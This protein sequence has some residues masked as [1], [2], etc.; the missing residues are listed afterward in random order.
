M[1]KGYSYLSFEENT[2]TR[3]VVQIKLVFA[4][5]LDI[6]D[7]NYNEISELQGWIRISTY[8]AVF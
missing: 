1:R 7:S 2:I 6:L 5:L 8:L 4:C 3:F